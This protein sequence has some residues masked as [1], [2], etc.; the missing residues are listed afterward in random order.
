MTGEFYR[1]DGTG[2]TTDDAWDALPRLQQGYL[3]IARFGGTDTDNA[4]KVADVV[5]VWPVRVSQRSNSR[6][7]RGEA[8]RFTSKFALSA[9]PEFAARYVRALDPDVAPSVLPS[10]RASRGLLPSERI[11]KWIV[12][13]ATEWAAGRN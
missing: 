9:D 7:T 12:E 5:E 11:V 1:D 2:S 13:R 6:V 8:L 4:I 10:V 3:V